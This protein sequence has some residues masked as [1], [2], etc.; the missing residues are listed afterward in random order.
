MQAANYPAASTW[1]IGRIL[2]L[3]SYLGLMAFPIF[4]WF[5]EL[6]FFNSEWP[7]HARFHMLWK[8]VMLVILGLTGFWVLLTHWQS[9]ITL[10]FVRWIPAVVWSTHIISTIG[11]SLLV[12]E[13]NLAHHERLILGVPVADMVI[14]LLLIISVTGALLDQRREKSL[15]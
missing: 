13:E 8:A 9:T 10:A 12:E 7:I 14:F 15:S 5:D 4:Y 11:M 2:L 6:H 1:S 3:L